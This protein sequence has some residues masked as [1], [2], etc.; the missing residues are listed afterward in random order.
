[1]EIISFSQNA[2]FIKEWIFRK[3]TRYL[4]KF[5]L[6]FLFFVIRNLTRLFYQVN[7][8][9]FLLKLVKLCITLNKINWIIKYC[10]LVA[11]TK[12]IYIEVL[13]SPSYREWKFVVKISLNIFQSLNWK[14]FQVHKYYI[15]EYYILLLRSIYF[16]M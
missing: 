7:V 1:M 6:N 4:K 12:Y 13:K 10:L 5:I 8:W 2:M 15:H 16:W 11:V 14:L 3:I 9:R